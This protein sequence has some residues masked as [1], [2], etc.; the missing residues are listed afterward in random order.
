MGKKVS[1]WSGNRNASSRT[2]VFAGFSVYTG[3][4]QSQTTELRRRTGTEPITHHVRRKRWKWIDHVLCTPLINSTTTSSLLPSD[5]PLITVRRE[6]DR[7]KHGG[8]QWRERERERE[9]ERKERER[10][11]VRL[12]GTY[13]TYNR[14]LRLR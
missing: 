3:R 4:T 7:K 14:A 2:G 1:R 9:R 13:A 5:G 12:K 11:R 6:V 8:R 10:E